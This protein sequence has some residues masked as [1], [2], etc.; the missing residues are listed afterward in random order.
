MG[1]MTGNWNTNFSFIW[2]T[3]L[4]LC[5]VRKSIVALEDTNSGVGSFISIYIVDVFG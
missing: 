4:S 3:L 1:P 5:R 2:S